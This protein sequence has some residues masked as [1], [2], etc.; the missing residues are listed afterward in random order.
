M[1]C[2]GKVW[3]YIRENRTTV[4]EYR[5]L[6]Y[7]R[8]AF[9]D[10]DFYEPGTTYLKLL[11]KDEKA[12]KKVRCSAKLGVPCNG[13]LWF[14]TKPVLDPLATF[15]NVESDLAVNEEKTI[16]SN[17]LKLI[18]ILKLMFGKQ[19]ITIHMRGSLDRFSTTTTG[20]LTVLP[21]DILQAEAYILKT[22]TNDSDIH[23]YITRD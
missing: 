7:H 19:N 18:D 17:S 9:Y 12:V 6:L 10:G 22:A 16:E 13:T 3:A 14:Y 11:D 20:A 1:E 21:D 4:K 8:N 5:A 15:A 23:I 2:M